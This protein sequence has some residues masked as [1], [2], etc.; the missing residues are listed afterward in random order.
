MA[1]KP[2]FI[3]PRAGNSEPAPAGTV[4]LP[5][6]SYHNVDDAA[7]APPPPEKT[8]SSVVSALKRGTGG[9]LANLALA[10]EDAGLSVNGVRQFGEQLEADNPADVTGGISDIAGHPLQF[11]KETAGELVPQVGVSFGAARVGN[12]LGGVL[13]GLAG[14]EGVVPGAYIGGKLGQFGANWLQEYGGIRRSAKETGVDDPGRAALAATGAAAL[15]TLAPVDL[16]AGR[17]ARKGVEEV[18]A[19]TVGSYVKTGVLGGLGEGFT[20]PSQSWIE[21]KGAGQPTSG[22]DATTDYVQS[23]AK[24]ALGG[25]ALGVIEHATAPHAQPQTTPDTTPP[26]ASNLP[27]I[28][29]GSGPTTPGGAATA[30]PT[31]AAPAAGGGA[32]LALPAPTRALPAPDQSLPEPTPQK[33]LP[34]QRPSQVWG[35][36][37]ASIESRGHG[38]YA[39]LGPVTSKGDR[40]IGRYGIMGRNVPAW[41]REALGRQM[42]PEEFAQD[43]A[44]QD[45]VFDHRFGHYVSTY[46]SPAEA[47]S[48]WFT[49]HR[50]AE[51][52]NRHDVLGTTGNEYVRKFNAA[53]GGIGGAATATGGRDVGDVIAHIATSPSTI[54]T[55]IKDI[56]GEDT[57]V[58]AKPLAKAISQGGD[59]AAEAIGKERKRLDS[60]RDDLI[61]VSD[62]THSSVIDA[63]LAHLARRENVLKAATDVAEKLARAR[64]PEIVTEPAPMV[65]PFPGEPQPNADLARTGEMYAA[66]GAQ[67][68][69]NQFS[70]RSQM[71]A[72][73]QATATVAAMGAKAEA[74]RTKSLA[75]VIASGAPDIEGA[76][77]HVMGQIEG[78]PTSLTEEE[79]ALV[80]AEKAHRALEAQQ[81]ARDQAEEEAKKVAEA[82]A[83]FAAE[84]GVEAEN[85]SDA[86]PSREEKAYRK[87]TQARA[88]G[89]AYRGREAGGRRR[90]HRR[91][92]R[93]HPGARA[94]GGACQG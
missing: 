73:R 80:N 85:I 94:C 64:G 5:I 42:T 39:A 38:D 59:A 20:E 1:A 78:M 91:A 47:A 53:M 9:V 36:A 81:E 72:A 12:V 70:A 87:R 55:Q 17:F 24:G 11:A 40:A 90:A 48:V 61:K 68:H 31:T 74:L 88:G 21:R 27:A 44:A 32:Q 13:G 23:A 66:Q 93:A 7:N 45:A 18:T 89:E 49:G 52:G 54:E 77:G 8:P 79:T 56:S 51:G 2:Q 69:A 46:G 43:H 65:R 71:D 58:T 4:I 63:K 30:G 76:F 41:T 62:T 6:G 29:P 33:L 92:A 34:G 37:I 83:K 3:D 50:I 84:R 35:P 15:D 26:P 14:P 16:I 10:G 67:E 19:K 57:T 82:N 86:V 75:R 60:A 28:I 25:S 22:P